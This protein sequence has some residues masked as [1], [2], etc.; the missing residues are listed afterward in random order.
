MHALLCAAKDKSCPQANEAD[1]QN[2]EITQACVRRDTLHALH[3]PRE[4]PFFC[5]LKLI[6][7]KTTMINDGG[8][9]SVGCAQHGPARFNCT[10]AGNRQMLGQRNR[11][12]KPGQIADIEQN[13]GMLV[14]GDRRR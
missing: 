6:H 5:V 3:L 12:T 9:T 7:H 2:R 10:H 1:Q 14:S 11:I 4:Q 13:G 8:G